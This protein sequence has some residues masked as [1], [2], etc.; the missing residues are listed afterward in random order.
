M[1][2][3]LYNHCC[4]QLINVPLWDMHGQQGAPAIVDLNWFPGRR[5]DFFSD[6]FRREEHKT[7]FTSLLSEL[8]V[9][10][11]NS[12]H[13]TLKFLNVCKICIIRITLFRMQSA[14]AF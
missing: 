10:L 11:T 8:G 13:G 5:P 2:Q 12:T 4:V 6:S 14:P 3:E 7:S 1:S 9:K